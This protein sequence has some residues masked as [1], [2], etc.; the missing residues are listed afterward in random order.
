MLTSNWILTAQCPSQLGTVDDVIGHLYQNQHYIDELHSF[1]DSS[2][3]QFSICV[4]FR[5]QR[6]LMKL[7]LNNHSR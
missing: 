4:N 1:D 7:H 3:Q 5:V 6:G 2:S